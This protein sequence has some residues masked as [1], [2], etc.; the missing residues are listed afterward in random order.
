M[1]GKVKR[2]FGLMGNH[3]QESEILM[4]N[5]PGDISEEE[6]K[7]WFIGMRGNIYVDLRSDTGRQSKD[8]EYSWTRTCHANIRCSE[9]STALKAKK[10]LNGKILRRGHILKTSIKH[11]NDDVWFEI[12]NCGEMDIYALNIS[13]YEWLSIV[14]EYDINKYFISKF[15][16]EFNNLKRL[17]RKNKLTFVMAP[18]IDN[19]KYVE[20]NNLIKFYKICTF[21]RCDYKRINIDSLNEKEI[22]NL[23]MYREVNILS[24]HDNNFQYLLPFGIDNTLEDML[25]SMDLDTYILNRNMNININRNRNNNNNHISVLCSQG[26][27]GTFSHSKGG[28][29]NSYD[30]ACCIGTPIIAPRNGIIVD[31][32]DH[33]KK[34]GPDLQY[35]KKCNYITILHSDGSQC[36]LVHLR[37]K[38]I[39]YKKGDYVRQ[40]DLIAY[41]GNTGFSAEPHVHMMVYL[42]R[43]I[44]D[45]V[46]WQSIPI[47]FKN[48]CTKNG[49]N[50]NNNN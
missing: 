9:V 33:H 24:E 7:K 32:V 41:S 22:P 46:R 35:E 3:G 49:N 28:Y 19:T 44:N 36:D 29:I 25:L 13:H 43:L 6:I 2:G 4:E 12:N 18:C 27:G 42:N 50:N 5:L 15:H 8:K 45:K 20:N 40:G 39:Q 47:K 38:S 11:L 48:P 10:S 21:K 30:F 14:I 26:P 31:I 16:K 23:L 37:Y 34:H 1:N 17:V